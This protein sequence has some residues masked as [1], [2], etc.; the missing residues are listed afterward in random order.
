MSS[1]RSGHTVDL[2]LPESSCW[3]HR[4]LAGM[5]YEEGASYLSPV[6]LKPS[7]EG[8]K[9]PKP[10]YAETATTTLKAQMEDDDY[11]LEDLCYMDTHNRMVT[12]LGAYRDQLEA[13]T[14]ADEDGSRGREV[15]LINRMIGY[16]EYAQKIVPDNRNRNSAV[17]KSDAIKAAFPDLTAKE[18]QKQAKRLYHIASTQ[19][20][21][22]RRA[23][24]TMR[25]AGVGGALANMGGA[26]VVYRDEITAGKLKPGAPMQYWNAQTLW[27]TDGKEHNL[28]GKQVYQAIVSNK[29]DIKQNREQYGDS[30]IAGHSVTF[31]KYSASSNSIINYTDYNG[32]DLNEKDI[33][34]DN[35]YFVAANIST[36]GEATKAAEYVLKSTGFRADAGKDFIAKQAAR[37]N[38]DPAKLAAAL[39]A[40]ITASGHSALATIQASVAHH[41]VPTAFDHDMSRLIGLWQYAVGA[42]VDGLFGN[43]S[44]AKLTGA[45]LKSATTLQITAPVD[46]AEPKKPVQD[47]AGG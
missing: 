23:P 44:C 26:E 25:G 18:G 16:L 22:V 38:L 30:S 46:V 39:V 17:S 31:V 27:L 15:A 40:G 12:V 21:S 24:G 19:P 2:H 33:S 8:E 35:P 29:V 9:K 5:S 10:T 7:E 28:T 45:K 11:K 3:T 4:T 6:Q 20:G 14:E 42:K 43:G 34:G 36:G 47:A 1:Q 32:G 41:G 37:Y 13:V